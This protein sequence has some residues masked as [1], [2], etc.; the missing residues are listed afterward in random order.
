M[1]GRIKPVAGSTGA[2]RQTEIIQLRIS[3]SP[4]RLGTRHGRWCGRDPSFT[5]RRLRT[6]TTWSE[7]PA[8]LAGRERFIEACGWQ[9]CLR[10]DV[11]GYPFCLLQRMSLKN[12]PSRHIA[13]PNDLGRLQGK[14]EIDR[15]P[16]IT[17][18]DARD[19]ERTLI[20]RA[21]KG[22]NRVTAR[23]PEWSGSSLGRRR[24]PAPSAARQAKLP[25]SPARHR[26][27]R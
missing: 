24:A 16:S 10:D 5:V 21:A 18:S 26:P 15:P 9:G 19:P 1:E 11:Q 3:I 13:P 23:P 27:S 12:G 20:G 4:S 17:E 2:S 8:F 22:I 14:A 6:T 7:N 25:S